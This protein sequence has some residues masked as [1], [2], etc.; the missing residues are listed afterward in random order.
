MVYSLDGEPVVVGSLAGQSLARRLDTGQNPVWIG[1]SIAAAT[2]GT[3]AQAP[4][5]AATS[6]VAGV[7]SAGNPQFQRI[8]TDRETLWTVPAPVPNG[9]AYSWI[10]DGEGDTWVVWMDRLDDYSN[11]LIYVQVLARC[12]S[13]GSISAAMCCGT[14]RA[15]SPTTIRG[16]GKANSLS[17]TAKAACSCLRASARIRCS[18]MENQ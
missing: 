13:R 1:E 5:G 6:V 18:K 11:P 7:D 17:A 15:A 9:H 10:C 16:A 12:T 14:S 2:L 8:G 3:T 4:L